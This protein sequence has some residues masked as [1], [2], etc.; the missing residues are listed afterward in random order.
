[1]LPATVQEQRSMHVVNIHLHLLRKCSEQQTLHQVLE[2][3]LFLII[4]NT[5]C[6]Q[7]YP[8]QDDCTC[9]AGSRLSHSHS[10]SFYAHGPFINYLNLLA[11][12]DLIDLAFPLTLTSGSTQIPSEDNQMK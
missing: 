1:M 10:A 5:H 4:Q 12:R 9:T 2:C 3:K 11:E 6:A 8:Q 7:S